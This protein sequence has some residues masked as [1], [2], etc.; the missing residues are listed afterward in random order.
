MK[1]SEF[2]KL[3]RQS[4]MEEINEG[5]NISNADSYYSFL[6]E[7]PID[8]NALDK[9]EQAIKSGKINP[10]TVEAAAKKAQSGDSS[11]L[12]A[13]MVTG[14]GFAKLEEAEGE[15]EITDTEV[16]I[17]EPAPEAPDMG[18]GDMTSFAG[19]PTYTPE[20][21]EVMDSLD[22]ALKQA[23]DLG[24]E[25]LSTLIGNIITYFTRQHVVKEGS[26]GRKKHY[27]GAVKDD[28]EQISK[29]KKDM[30]FDKKQLQKESLEILKMKKLA[31]LL[32]EGEYAKALL[33]ENLDYT[34]EE[35]KGKTVILAL[36]EDGDE[37]KEFTVINTPEDYEELE[38]T[39]KKY[40]DE[41][42]LDE[43]YPVLNKGQRL[44]EEN[45]G[46]DLLM[47]KLKKMSSQE[48]TNFVKKV[49][50]YN[51]WRNFPK[52]IDPF[53]NISDRMEVI[54][55]FEDEDVNKYLNTLRSNKGQ[56]LRE[57]DSDVYMSFDKEKW[58]DKE[59]KPYAGGFD[60]DYDEETFD[61]FDSFM[62]KYGG[63]QRSFRPSDKST[64][65][66]YKNKYNNMM[67]R[68]RK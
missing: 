50:D 15:E 20:E 34:F 53:N 48:F 47:A 54:S 7:E 29:L 36:I 1:L 33:R 2:K 30:K 39:V 24:D 5:D 6:S 44:R 8:E 16:D 55:T 56:R 31:G 45:S 67:M 21:A 32:K 27:K 10:K 23:Q 28:E 3:I 63:K 26:A 42:I 4:V 40:E 25:K 61:D 49:G 17:T 12:A 38:R 62:S 66:M 22:N 51:L 18:A 19:E 14:Q 13:L 37:N 59:D 60:F 68:K 52:G 46:I 9:I 58:F 35:L 65:D 43:Y 64:F 11:E 41:G 57:E